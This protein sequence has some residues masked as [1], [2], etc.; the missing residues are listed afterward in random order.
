VL[1][2]ASG[3]GDRAVEED[4]IS[5]SGERRRRARLDAPIVS[6]LVVLADH[7]VNMVRA[8]RVVTGEDSL[9]TELYCKRH[10]K[11]RGK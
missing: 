8:T 3:G 9:Q 1:D 4:R 11:K 6:N 7:H 2:G 10:R 5:F